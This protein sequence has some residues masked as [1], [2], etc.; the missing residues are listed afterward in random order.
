MVLFGS[1]FSYYNYFFFNNCVCLYSLYSRKCLIL[2]CKIFVFITNA[3]HW[4]ALW[5]SINKFI[6]LT[7]LNV[8]VQ[9]LF[10]KIKLIFNFSSKLLINYQYLC[11]VFETLLSHKHWSFLQHSLH[12]LKLGKFFS[13]SSYYWRIKKINQNYIIYSNKNT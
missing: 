1:L 10:Q 9:E 11:K 3:H 5:R 8:L 4:I 13:S 7:I 6:H 12:G 2:C